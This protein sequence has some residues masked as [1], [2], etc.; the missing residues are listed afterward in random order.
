MF[1]FFYIAFALS[2][3]TL[4][5]FLLKLGILKKQQPALLKKFFEDAGGSFVKFGQLLALRVDILPKEYTLELLDLFDNVK[6]V[7]YKEIE[8]IFLQELGATPQRIY[9]DFQQEP[10]ASASFGQV[11]AAKLEDDTI[12]AVKILRPGIESDVAVDFFFFDIFAFLG[13]LFFKIEAMPWKEFEQEFKKWTKEELDYHIEAENL[14]KMYPLQFSSQH[15]IY[16]KVYPK[17]STKKILTQ[18]YIDGI[19][20]S[21]ILR[22]LRSG[23]LTTQ[24]LERMGIDIKNAPRLLVAEILRQ[25]FYFGIFHADP[26]PGNILLLKDNKIGLVDF[27]IL[28]DQKIPNQE[29]LID[30]LINAGSLQIKEAAYFAMHFAGDELKQMVHSAFPATVDQKYIDEFMRILGDKFVESISDQ[31]DKGI[32]DL[33]EMKVDYSLLLLQM[34]KSAKGYKVKVPQQLVIFIRALAIIGLM[35]KELDKTFLLGEELVDFFK[36]NPKE[37]FAQHT[38]IS[39]KRIN[40]E[41][42]LEKLN[43]WLSYLFEKDPSLYSLVNNYIEKYTKIST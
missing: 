30:F 41:V 43:N 9:K 7:P 17:Y 40:R 29:I 11:H 5:Y 4:L 12:V 28:G 13:D 6:P 20:L 38:P 42:A 27:G 14:E 24:D 19:P 33:Y 37:K 16:P 25:H 34:L 31:I 22:G 1:R 10:F 18:Q 32:E 8:T 2:R 15:V 23:K 3:Y 35:A 21:R 36:K 26:H 39:Y